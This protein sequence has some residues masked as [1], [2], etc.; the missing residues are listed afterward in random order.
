MRRIQNTG[1]RSRPWGPVAGLAVAA[2]CLC[3]PLDAQRGRPSLPLEQGRNHDGVR[4]SF[5]AV[6]ADVRASVVRVHGGT[7]ALA[8]GTAV[9]KGGILVT[10]ASEV[11]D[12]RSLECELADGTRV[13]ARLL[14]EDEAADLAVLQIDTADGLPVPPW[15]ADMPAVG[16]LLATAGADE[17]PLAIGVVSLP[18]YEPRTRRRGGGRSDA[19]RRP[20]RLGVTYRIGTGEAT[21]S[22]VLNGSAA[23][24]AGILSGD[25]VLE[26]DGVTVSSSGSMVE[27]LRQ[28]H[29]GDE[30]TLVIQRGEVE[31]TI[32]VVLDAAPQ[33]NRRPSRAERLWGDLSEVRSGFPRVLQHDTVLEP[34]Q[35]GTPIVTLDG[36][37]AGINIA[38]VGRIESWA[39]PADLVQEVVARVL[40]AQTDGR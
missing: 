6:I 31:K 10:K 19:P 1:P 30:V 13:P 24:E 39:L 14:G 29:A 18:V 26:L 37:V 40:A 35:C 9:A 20:G 2:L 36:Q 3:A 32:T 16:R 21:I 33:R 12:A 8:Y 17:V 11:R 4:R 7:A 27:A 15:V 25:V 23:D 5:A 22:R 38:R 28:H 34:D